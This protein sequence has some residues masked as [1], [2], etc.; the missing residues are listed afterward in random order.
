M[1]KAIHIEDE[2]RNVLLL[3]SLIKENCSKKIN[4]IATATNVTDAIE[5]IR[6]HSPQLVFLDIE[7]NNGNSFDLLNELGNAINFEII[8]ITAYNQYA[9]KAFRLHA[10]D[11]LL[12]PIS[13]NELIEATEKAIKKI[14]TKS[15]FQV[16]KF[17]SLKM[18]QTSLI[19]QKIGLPI[20]VGIEFFLITDIIKFRTKGSISIM[21]LKN[22]KQILIYKS[23]KELEDN[24]PK[25]IFFR[26]HTSWLI[27]VQLVKKF[28]KGANAYLVM[29]DD[30][31][32]EV[33]VRK[34]TDFLEMF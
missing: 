23:L 33:S 15:N 7:L 16:D 19:I 14:D 13:I 3:D 6:I 34:K 17:Q 26:V 25:R 1:I 10:I 9:I 4:I 24:L 22:N 27:N 8:F 30:S 12:K 20:K 11:Y 29:E 5:I 32:V 28:Y 21:Y 31:I 2:P 18:L